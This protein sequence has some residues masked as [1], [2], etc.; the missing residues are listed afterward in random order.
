MGDQIINT[1]I[2]ADI[3]QAEQGIRSVKRSIQ[4]MSDTAGS[5]SKEMASVFS[6]AAGQ[7]A[8][9]RTAAL[10]A[11]AAFGSLEMAK[12]AADAVMFAANVEQANRALQVIANTMGM[13]SSVAMKYRDS[14]RDIGITTNSATNATAQ[15]IRGGMPLDKL[16]QLG[17]AAQGAAIAYQMMSGETISS[18][19]ALDKMVRAIMTGNSQELH[20]LGIN[21]MMRDSLRNNKIATG[22]SANSVDTHARKLLLFNDVLKETQ[23]LLNLYAA[24]LDLASKQIA[25]S[26]RPVEELKLALGNLFLPELTVAATAFFTVVTD[27]MKWT[28]VHADEMKALADSITMISSAA[29]KAGE[30]YL[31]Y[32]VLIKGPALVSA[33]M[34]QVQAFHAGQV[35]SSTYAAQL[36]AGNVVQLGSV[37]A[38]AMKATAQAE[39]AQAVAAATLVEVDY[40]TSLQS[41]MIAER[42]VATAKLQSIVANDD[43]ISSQLILKETELTAAASRTI[44]QKDNLGLITAEMEALT[45]K[46]VLTK[47]EAAFANELRAAEFTAINRVNL[48][49]QEQLAIGIELSKVQDSSAR[50]NQSRNAALDEMALASKEAAASTALLT[51]Q[52]AINEKAQMRSIAVTE[53]ATVAV[54]TSRLA[55]LSLGNAMNLAFAGWIGW[56]IG[57]YLQDQFAIVRKA[58]VVM[59]YGLMDAWALAGEAYERFK[60]TMNPFG[61]EEKQQ[62]ELQSIRDRYAAE[63]AI[64]DK[65]R[66][67]Q[68][69]DVEKGK[70][71]K[72]PYVDKIGTLPPLTPSPAETPSTD[73]NRIKAALDARRAQDESFWAWEDAGYKANAKS[74]VAALEWQKEQGLLTVRAFI[75]QKEQIEKGAIDKEIARNNKRVAEMQTSLTITMGPGNDIYSDQALKYTKAQTDL[76]KALT[77]G[78]ELE[79]QKSGIIQGATIAREKDVIDQIK[80]EI[81][82]R[83]ELSALNATN[84]A[85][86]AAMVGTNAAGGFDSISDQTANAMARQE[87]AYKRQLELIEQKRAAEQFAYDHSEKNIANELK[88][89]G[90]LAALDKNKSLAQQENSKATTGIALTGFRSQLSAAS[91]YTGMAGQ[92]FTALASTQDQSSRKG[93]ET[94]KAF[95]LAAAVMSTAAAVMNALATVP[96]PMSIAAAVLAAATGAIQIATI[97]STSFGGGAGNV[98]APS[99]SFASAS[100]GGSDSGLSNLAVP[101]SSV[102]DSQTT[103]SLAAL[104]KSTDN[105]SVVIGRLSKSIDSLNALFKDGG[106]GMGLA[107]NAPERFTGLQTPQSAMSSFYTGS[108]LKSFIDAGTAF[109]T[110]DVKTL[111]S[112]LNPANMVNSVSN[113]I[114]GGSV[115]TTGAGLSLGVRDGIIA[116]SNYVTTNTDGGWFGSDRQNTSYSNN[117]DAGTFVQALMQPFVS[118]ITRM[119][120]TLGT[121][122]NTGSVNMPGSNIAT[123]GRSA[124]D[125]AKDVQA[126]SLEVLQSMSMT[127][128]GLKDVVGSYDDAYARLKALNDAL[129]STND[130]FLLIGKTTIQ[131]TLTNARAV[132][133]LQALMGGMDK[134]TTAVNDYFTGMFTGAQQDAMT[135]ASDSQKVNTAFGEMRAFVPSTKADFIALA[136]SLDVTSASGAMLFAALMQISPAFSEMTDLVESQRKAIADFNNDLTA[137][138]MKLDGVNGD[139]FNLRIAQEDEMKKAVL[140][141]MDTNALAIVQTREWANAVNTASG[142]ITASI[143]SIRD[144][145][146]TA[147]I[148][149]VDAQIA[150]L[151]LM[152]TIQTG[153]LANMSPEAAYK[154]ALT[155]FNDVKGKTDLASVQALPVAVTA[156]LDA[157]KNYSSDKQAYMSDVAK[158]LTA[159]A[160][161]SGASGSDLPAIESQLEVLQDIRTSLN[162][163]ALVEALGADGTLA[164]LL[165]VFNT[166]TAATLAETAKQDAIKQ[167]RDVAAVYNASQS[168]LSSQYTYGSVTP[169]QYTDQTTAAYTS[170]KT[171]YDTAIA[172]P[173][174]SVTDL[175]GLNNPTITTAMSDARGA[176]AQAATDAAAQATAARQA[177]GRTAMDAKAA[178]LFVDDN[179]RGGSVTLA[180]RSYNNTASMNFSND[181]LSSIKVAPG[182]KATMYWDDNLSGNSLGF[183]GDNPGVGHWANDEMS[184]MKIERVD[185]YPAFATGGDHYGGFRIVGENGP[186]LEATGA[187]R[188]FNADQTRNIF[189]NGSADNRDMVAEL[190]A[191][192][193]EVR[194]LRNEQKAGHVAIAKNTGESAKQ[195]RRWDGEGTPP[196]RAAA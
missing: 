65:F 144:A 175:I 9:L 86:E 76:N 153:P 96:Y 4:D 97:A 114:F 30:V 46:G 183:T 167:S 13:S 176:V 191:L 19:Q 178:T 154:Q 77:K 49:Q 89:K 70:A 94:A 187:S 2:T 55:W 177:Q 14:L 159:L 146:K 125:I 152:K 139:L 28:R 66:A 157:S 140:D 16:N 47:K 81:A 99:G 173:G 24:S 74:A 119:A 56:E 158:G 162:E 174:V 60:A 43:L 110:F 107:T 10:G 72:T 115:S 3:A 143:T 95:S 194:E 87:D 48:A 150:I 134:F 116:A 145:A 179:Y 169:T 44:A 45:A 32:L 35:A 8:Q 62:K 103:E 163:G 170:A 40:A 166:A 171:K 68:M 23:P 42:E 168:S 58:G 12:S 149:M 18:S 36:E 102:Q 59:A 82:V 5:A 39:A 41:V 155:T 156:L 64:R 51:E 186:E 33:V 17:T 34:A 98:S 161:A 141:G 1:I 118:D 83:N 7:L 164:Q 190:R 188:I 131:G 22:E 106:A 31:G 91:Q 181:V 37:K 180:A 92:F 130:S 26:K 80:N 101:L 121:T 148:S 88:L 69:I 112:M 129:V 127:V 78:I 195:L 113:A 109:A 61:D 53:S 71:V 185:P 50:S 136:N 90:T 73:F 151:N 79:A 6:F 123:A 128:D 20:T 52:I 126:W 192:R 117:A 21:V 142:V 111:T 160:L 11:A 172:T 15:F 137:R 196:V 29:F 189:Q 105:A 133:A 120:M 75:D 147:A 122:A 85:R 84:S 104:T 108:G 182:Y 184:S 63:K 124:E 54:K 193:E 38:I 132:E 93:F 138:T 57:T 27:G 165:G 67:E 25:S 135:A 100:G